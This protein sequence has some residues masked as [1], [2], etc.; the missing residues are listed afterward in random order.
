MSMRNVVN[1]IRVVCVFLAITCF[2]YAAENISGEYYS[3]Q[4]TLKPERP[5]LH[6]YSQTL[7]MKMF[8]CSRD[9]KGN[10][11]KVYLRFDEALEVI[12]K[13]DN[14]TLG[15]PKIV[16]VVGWQF[17]G[18]DSGYPS[19]SEVNGHLKRPE[20]KTALQSLRWLIREAKKYHTTI[21]LHINMIDAFENSP[22][23][24]T[25]DEANIILKDK[26]GVPIKG[27]V[28]GGM[29]SYQISYAQEWKLG[30]AQKRIDQLLHMVPELKESGTIH[31]DAFHSIQAARPN[32]SLSSPYLGITVDEE[33]A[34]QR[35]IFRY[36]R[37]KGIDVTAEADIY[38]LRR[39]PF[40]GLQPMAWWFSM[41]RFRKFDWT[42]KPA[43]FKTLPASLYTWTPMHAEPEIMKD[44]EHL[45]GLIKQFC[46]Q[47]VPWFYRNHVHMN[48][49]VEMDYKEDN[50]FLP[51]LWLPTTMVAYSEKGFDHK[52]VSLPEQWK[53]IRTVKLMRITTEGLQPLGVLP[54]NN[55]TI[56]LTT[57]PGDAIAVQGQS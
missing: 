38:E 33:I 44:P 14:L 10:V 39:D 8:L 27:E 52:T 11:D 34:A 53:G 50:V 1:G 42:G 49:D 12:K 22:L 24:K 41:A 15:I 29:Q 7:V 32:D 43:D 40:I 57:E 17:T 19:W 35:K 47:V 23:W 36:W 45:T 48:E 51:A 16:Y 21:S 2:A 3:W 4:K 54:V 37:N 31:I 46:A 28:F 25:Y 9:G 30:L 26:S 20:D 6:D 18:H 5:W 56:E 13:L 55:D